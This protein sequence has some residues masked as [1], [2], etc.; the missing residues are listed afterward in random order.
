M[1]RVRQQHTRPELL[2]RRALH[3]RGLRYRL[4]VRALPGSP[5]L[6]LPRFRA[7][8]FVH[9]CFWH[10]HGCRRTTTPRTNAAFWEAKFAANVV[11]DARKQAGLLAYFWRVLV[12]WEC[13]LVGQDARSPDEVAEDVATWL[14]SDA[15]HGEIAGASLLKK[16]R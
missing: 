13:A 16:D 2:L 1:S 12:V 5:D 7:C 11:R 4:H 6:V 8:V 15:T 3:R 14:T 10:R 9:G